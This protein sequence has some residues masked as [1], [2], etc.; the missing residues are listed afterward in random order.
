M[1]LNKLVSGSILEIELPQNIGFAYCIYILANDDDLIII[2]LKHFSENRIKKIDFQ[3]V[4]NEL[5]APIL[6]FKPTIRGF[7]KWPII[8]FED[9]NKFKFE[10][11]IFKRCLQYKPE[12]FGRE[13][14]LRWFQIS[15]YDL[16]YDTV[17]DISKNNHLEEF[18]IY[19]YRH[20]QIRLLYEL[21]EFYHFDINFEELFGEIAAKVSYEKFKVRP[22]YKDIPKKYWGRLIL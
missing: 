15:N 17:L 7:Y 5:T 18:T 2:P 21:N 20:I 19:S 11:A 10:D 14:E 1:N 22:R 6:T 12:Y 4:D 3:V 8:G 9:P 16:K 13:T